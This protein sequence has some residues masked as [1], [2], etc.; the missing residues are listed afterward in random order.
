MEGKMSVNEALGKSSG[1]AGVKPRKRIPQEVSILIVLAGISLL[2]ELLGW[3]FKGQS[4]L[5]NADR[6]SIIFLQTAVVGI[7]AVGVAQTIITG[8]V[9]LSSGSVVGATAMISAS[10][11]Q[12]ATARSIVYPHFAD[13]PFVVPVLAGLVA[14]LLAGVVNGALIAYASV[15]PFIATL[16]MMV[17]ARGFATWYTNGAPIST[18]TPSFSIIGSSTQVF[19]LFSIN[20]P[21]TI[22]LVVALI[23]HIAMCYT[24]YGKFTYA[25]GSNMQAARVSGI[26]VKRHLVKVY[27]FAGLLSG[28]AGVVLIARGGSG[29]AGMGLGY[30]LQ[31][32]AAVVI[33]GTSLS[34]GVGRITS[35]VIGL[36]ILSVVQSGFT[37]LGVQASLQQIVL[38]AIIV[39]A[40]V[41]DQYRRNK[42]RKA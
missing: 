2:F 28:L 14:G 41:I 17:S 24:R 22:F 33:G 35:T 10:L 11:A 29:Q 39:T 30:E 23:F 25:I 20:W 19:G 31:A 36:L 34:G 7:I 16:G 37:F 40:V 32:I 27:G 26:D 6:L 15:P 13:L 38:G 4:F 42:R 12:V 8:G 21:I 3:P 1:S 5:L 9:D 18:F